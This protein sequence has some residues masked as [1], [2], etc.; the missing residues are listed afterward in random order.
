MTIGTCESSS[1]QA[2]VLR[3]SGQLQ[4]WD[5]I[6]D[7]YSGICV[8]S[9]PDKKLGG[10]LVTGCDSGLQGTFA[11]ENGRIVLA[12]DP[13][14]CVVP[15]PDVEDGEDLGVTVVPCAESADQW[16]VDAQDVIASGSAAGESVVYIRRSGTSRCLTVGW[17]F[18]SVVTFLVPEFVEEETGDDQRSDDDQIESEEPSSRIVVAILNESE[19]DTE[20]EFM[21]KGVGAVMSEVPGKAIQTYVLDMGDS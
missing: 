18:L 2:W 6:D 17:P 19:R 3:A 5:T 8:A 15:V 9:A 11:F 13:D 21:V 1:R 4:V 16:D 10:L 12:D 7:G 20:L 14:S